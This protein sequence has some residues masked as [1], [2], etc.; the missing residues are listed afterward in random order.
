MTKP[1]QLASCLFVLLSLSAVADTIPPIERVLPPVGLLPSEPLSKKLQKRLSQLRHELTQTT[2]DATTDADVEIFLKA[3]D[4]ALR[5]RE[6]YAESDFALATQSLDEAARRIALLGKREAPWKRQRGLVVRGYRSRVDR[7]AQPYGLVIPSELDF[8]KPSPLYVWLHGRG[9]KITDL[10]FIH[11]RQTRVGRIAPPDAIV[12]HPFGR[13]CLGFKHAGEIDVLDAIHSVRQRYRIDARKIVLMG[14]SM[15]G[16]GTWHIGAHYTDHFVAISPGAGFAETARYNQLTANA[17]PSWYGQIL[18][19]VYD[20]P[21]YARNF[22]NAPLIAYSGERDK[23][24]QAARVMETALATHGE[25]LRHVIGPKMGHNYDPDSLKEILRSLRQSVDAVDRESTSMRPTNIR[26]QTRTLRY[27]RMRSI[28][29]LQLHRHWDDTRVDASWKDEELTVQTRNVASL[30]LEVKPRIRHILVDRQRM[31]LPPRDAP[32]SLRL[33]KRKEAWQ[34]LSDWKP[35]RELTQQDPLLKRHGLQG[36]IDDA[37]LSPFLVV[38]PSGRS[39]HPEVQRWM[40]F[41]I[42]HFANRWRA[43]MRGELPM[44]RDDQVT[45]RDVQTKHLI[46]WGDSTSNRL[47]E[48]ISEALPIQWT[49]EVIRVARHEYSSAHHVPALIYPNPQNPRRYVVLNSGLTFREG[50]D[51][52]NSLQN[53]KLPDWAVIDVSQPP[54]ALAPGKVV[55]ADFFDESWQLQETPTQAHRLKVY[56]TSS[57]DQAEQ[58]CYISLPPKHRPGSPPTPL[59]VSLHS[60]SAGVEQ[61]RE[62]L[63]RLA[64][65]RGWICLL[66]HFRGP[67]NHPNACGSQRAQQDILDAVRW[68]QSRYAIDARRIYLT[69]VSGGGHMTMLM[70]ARHPQ[71]W[72]AASAWVGISDLTSWHAKHARSNY[73]RMMRNCCGGSPGDSSL[74]DLQYR[75]R[76]P[77]TFLHQAVDVPL[78]IAAGLHD[79]HQGSVPIRHSIDAFNAIA[80]SAGDASVDEEEI[81]QLSQ[82]DGRLRDPKASD[83]VEDPTF[84]RTIYLRRRAARSRLTIFEG[85]HEG[86]DSAAIAWL[87][88]HVRAD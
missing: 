81:Q 28:E 53:P 9:D 24:M 40:E 86:I 56:V 55:D 88:R 37:F 57:L 6:F 29:I 35:L 75:E 69:G 44:K 38:T 64:A 13:H 73:G 11:R 21:N 51:R 26:L 33:T 49:Q 52:T 18:W 34:W 22:M 84:G 15:G 23:Q 79:G 10:H 48:Q 47:I 5:H 20:V 78:D 45:A 60:W 72:A 70:A 87:A 25:R 7:S 36:P 43:L 39:A 85:G 16:A 17:Y 31:S 32:L 59:L 12:L 3:V 80:R 41:E 30:Q 4:Y 83:R 19:T 46:L 61:H 58:P 1:A 68:A 65:A 67:N 66:P 71:V 63:E 42:A 76:S 77:L 82:P 14:F 2:V 50:H 74:V 62:E 8:Q 27:N 54:D